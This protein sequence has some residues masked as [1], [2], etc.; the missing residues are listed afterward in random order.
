MYLYE[1]YGRE[2]VTGYAADRYRFRTPSLRNVV[3]TGPWG[4]AGAY[5]SLRDVVLHHLDPVA[6]L[7]GYDPAQAV[8]PPRVDLDAIDFIVHEDASRHADIGAANELEPVDLSEQQVEDLLAFL[9]TLTDPASIDLRV[10]VPFEVPSGL[11][12]YD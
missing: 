8:L 6:S 2:R 12:V 9:H 10:D 5:N 3:L 4:H 7:E 1:D 11:P